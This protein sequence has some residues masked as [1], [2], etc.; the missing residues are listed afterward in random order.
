MNNVSTIFS[1]ICAA[2]AGMCLISGIAVLTG[3]KVNGNA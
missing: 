1:Y 3:G 2:M